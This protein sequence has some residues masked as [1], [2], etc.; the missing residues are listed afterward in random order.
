MTTPRFL[1]WETFDPVLGCTIAEYCESCNVD[2]NEQK[3][4][5]LRYNMV[6]WGY[7]PSTADMEIPYHQSAKMLKTTQMGHGYGGTLMAT[8]RIQLSNAMV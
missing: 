4:K 5:L 1:C 2:I 6:Q 7:Q 8:W 3:G